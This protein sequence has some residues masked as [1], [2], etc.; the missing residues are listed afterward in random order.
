MFCYFYLISSQFKPFFFFW[1][2]Y[3][4]SHA[5]LIY[6]IGIRETN[7]YILSDE[8]SLFLFSHLSLLFFL[9]PPWPLRPIVRQ[10]QIRTAERLF[11]HQKKVTF[12]SRRADETPK[13][14]LEC[15]C[16]LFPKTKGTPRIFDARRGSCI[17]RRPIFL[18]D[19]LLSFCE[20]P[21][22]KKREKRID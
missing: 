12:N 11:I 10:S 20:M 19:S 9:R 13:S 4:I 17:N 8:F 7:G 22:L 1:D 21:Q 2:L 15:P 16:Y 5:P 6:N 3:D 18:F 14:N